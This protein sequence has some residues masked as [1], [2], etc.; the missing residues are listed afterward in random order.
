MLVLNNKCEKCN[1][2]CNAIHFQQEFE[3]WASGN[4]N[5]DKFIQNTQLSAHYNAK[6]ALEWIAYDRFCDIKSTTKRNIYKADWIDGYIDKWDNENQNWKRISKYMIVIL[7][8]LN[9]PKG[10][11]LEFA[12]EV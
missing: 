4:D 3:S 1:N 8:S 10:V 9:D 7:K 2:I 6:E 11:T 5:I 12:N